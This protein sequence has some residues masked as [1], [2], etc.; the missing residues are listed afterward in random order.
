[1]SVHN[2]PFQ[3]DPRTARRPAATAGRR[4]KRG[5]PG[6]RNPGGPWDVPAATDQPPNP[7]ET[8]LSAAEALFIACCTAL[9]SAEIFPIVVLGS[10]SLFTSPNSWS[11]LRFEAWNASSPA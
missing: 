8:T 5:P 2:P 4:A 11:H 1:M 6:Y 3:P 9:D 10:V 7:W